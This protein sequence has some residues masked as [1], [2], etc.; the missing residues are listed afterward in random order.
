MKIL[1]VIHDPPYGTERA[2]NALRL[3]RTLAMRGN[4]E[5]RLF[6]V[7]D[8]VGC[9][10]SNQKVPKGYYNLADMATSVARHGGVVGCCG[11]CM[12]AR[13]FADDQLV[14]GARRSSL[15]EWGEW[16]LWADKTIS[17]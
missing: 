11:S 10:L 13:G 12:D 8:G 4:V 1:F 9:A 2:Y 6:L 15:E 16:V 3:A 14:N 17:F 7:A 5:V